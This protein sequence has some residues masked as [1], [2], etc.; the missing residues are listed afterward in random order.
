MALSLRALSEDL[1]VLNPSDSSF[2]CG[3]FRARPSNDQEDPGLLGKGGEPGPKML[4]RNQPS[5]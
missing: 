2:G 5:S 1:R 4:K 3:C